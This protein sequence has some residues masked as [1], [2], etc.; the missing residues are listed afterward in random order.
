MIFLRDLVATSGDKLVRHLQH[1]ERN[2]P[3]PYQPCDDACNKEVL[4]HQ[5]QNV[6]DFVEFFGLNHHFS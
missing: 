1:T 4:R 6:V 2:G 5:D 3:P